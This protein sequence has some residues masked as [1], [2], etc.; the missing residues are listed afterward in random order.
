MKLNTDKCHLLVSGNRYENTFIT[1]GNDK[2]WEDRCVKLLGVTIDNKLNFDNHVQNICS[3]AVRKLSVLRRMVNFLS[4]DKKRLLLKSF[5][6]S[7]FAYCPL[8]WMLHSRESNNRIN[9]LRE[10]AI[11]L[12][13]NDHT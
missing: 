11:R 10:R 13:Y 5:V 7:Q 9:R 4:F 8:I 6:E 12:I 3:N 1:V 2:I